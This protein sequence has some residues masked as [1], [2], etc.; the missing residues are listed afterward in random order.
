MLYKTIRILLGLALVF[1]LSCNKDESNNVKQEDGTVWISGGLAYCAEQI[2]LDNGDTLI[3]SM[4]DVIPFTAGV[5][6]TV[7]YKETGLNESCSPGIN[8]EIIEIKKAQ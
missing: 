4:E 7:K 3:V 5:R 2:H 1:T 8:C 6:V